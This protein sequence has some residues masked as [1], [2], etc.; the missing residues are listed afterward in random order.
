MKF[1]DATRN[2]NA[3]NW[4]GYWVGGEWTGADWEWTD[5]SAFTFFN[6]NQG[7]P[8][9]FDGGEEDCLEIWTNGKWNDDKCDK[10]LPSVCQKAAKTEY[11]ELSLTS[12]KQK[13]CG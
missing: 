7:E 13:P 8:N 2:S 5:Q 12:G 3:E 4:E 1:L 6:W 9:N 10:E 11:C